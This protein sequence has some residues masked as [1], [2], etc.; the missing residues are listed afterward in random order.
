VAREHEQGGTAE[1]GT[2]NAA[3]ANGD[4]APQPVALIVDDEVFNQKI[5]EVALRKC[6]FKCQLASD[7]SDA[8]QL[9]TKEN[10]RFDVIII[11]Q[12]MKVMNG[13]VATANIRLHEMQQGLSPTPIICLTG[14]NTPEDKDSY[15]L[16]GMNGVLGKPVKVR[17]LGKSLLAYIEA[18]RASQLQRQLQLSSKSNQGMVVEYRAVEDLVVFQP[19]PLGDKDREAYTASAS[20]IT[21][22]LAD[23]SAQSS[24]RGALEET[25][26]NVVIASGANEVIAAVKESRPP[27]AVSMVL[28]S[29]ALPGAASCKQVATQIRQHEMM[30]GLE[31]VRILA[32]VD[33]TPD[34]TNQEHFFA[35]GMDG[36]IQR[37]VNA[38]TIAH[39]IIAYV[40]EMQKLRAFR[41]RELAL[42]KGDLIVEYRRL[43]DILVFDT[44]RARANADAR[45]QCGE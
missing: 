26:M 30:H 35:S 24:L 29:E 12:L 28:L 31:P 8:V 3:A 39:S 15:F 14:N 27:K 42:H 44:Q 34:Q 23:D 43:S 20:K 38:D 25:G 17:N 40:Q 2:S 10:R 33:A 45:K 7:G 18:N 6:G 16:A 5:V 13:T 1:V 9:V 19:V 11:D 37:P 22:V 32:F 41:F 4:N 36:I 21:V